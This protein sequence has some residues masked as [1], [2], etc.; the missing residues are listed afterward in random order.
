MGR[1]PRFI[2]ISRRAVRYRESEVYAWLEAQTQQQTGQ[3]S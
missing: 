3:A 2:K 1:G